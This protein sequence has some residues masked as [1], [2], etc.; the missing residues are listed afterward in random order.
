[1]CI[2]IQS[3]FKAVVLNIPNACD[4]LI[5]LVLYDVVSPNHKIIFIVATS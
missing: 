3:L 5:W 1:M 2:F 4:L